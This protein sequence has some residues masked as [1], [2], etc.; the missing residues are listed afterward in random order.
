M[1]LKAEVKITSAFPT[2]FCTYQCNNDAQETSALEITSAA[3]KP[4]S[5]ESEH[6]AVTCH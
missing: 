2:L 4:I 1:L 6:P 3:K 5:V